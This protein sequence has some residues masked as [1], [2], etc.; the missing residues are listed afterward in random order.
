MCIIPVFV[1]NF[2]TVNTIANL[3][4]LF[5]LRPS[6]LSDPSILKNLTSKIKNM[7]SVITKH[8]FRIGQISKSLKKK[9]SQ[10]QT[11][12]ANRRKFVFQGEPATDPY[13]RICFN[14]F[15]RTITRLL[16]KSV[17]SIKQFEKS[18]IQEY[19]RKG[20]VPKKTLSAF[21][22]HQR[23][24]IQIY[25]DWLLI[26]SIF[27]KRFPDNTNPLNPDWLRELFDLRVTY[28]LGLKITSS[29]FISQKE[30]EYYQQLSPIL[31]KNK[32]KAEDSQLKQD[33]GF[34]QDIRR[35]LELFHEGNISE[36][37]ASKI[38]KIRSQRVFQ[39]FLKEFIC[40]DI[41]SEKFAKTIS[42]SLALI[43]KSLETP[44]PF[45]KSELE[46]MVRELRAGL[47]RNQMQKARHF[48]LWYVVH[49]TKHG[50]LQPQFI[51]S[52]LLD[53][54]D[55]FGKQS[56]ELL[57]EILEREFYFLAEERSSSERFQYIV[58]TLESKKCPNLA[59][60]QAYHKLM[61]IIGNIVQI[62]QIRD[63]GLIDSTHKEQI[64]AKFSTSQNIYASKTEIIENYFFHVF[65]R[66]G[67]GQTLS[68][69]LKAL[70]TVADLGRFYR[71]VA[72][73]FVRYMKVKKKSQTRC[74]V[75]L[76]KML[77][78][79]HPF[80]A[81]FVKEKFFS[82][83]KDLFNSCFDDSKQT[84]T[85]LSADVVVFGE[86]GLVSETEMLK[87]LRFIKHIPSRRVDLWWKLSFDI[88]GQLGTVNF[89]R[90]LGIGEKH[91]QL[92]CRLPLSQLLN[93]LVD[94][95]RI[96]KM[97]FRS[98]TEKLKSIKKN[99]WLFRMEILTR[100][101]RLY[102]PEKGYS[103]CLL[104][105]ILEYQWDVRAL[106]Q[107]DS[108]NSYLEFGSFDIMKNVL[109]RVARGN[110]KQLLSSRRELYRGTSYRDILILVFNFFRE[111][112]ISEHEGRLQK[113]GKG[114]S[115]DVDIIYLTN[116]LFSYVEEVCR[117][118]RSSNSAIEPENK[119][120]EK[121]SQASTQKE[122][123]E[124]N[125]PQEI[126][127]EKEEEVTEEFE[128]EMSLFLEQQMGQAQDSHKKV[129]FKINSLK[130]TKNVNAP[131]GTSGFTLISR[132]NFRKVK[133]I[134]GQFMSK[135][136]HAKLFE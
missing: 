105:F 56:M 5:W 116:D 30:F 52:I 54:A 126:S 109:R 68:E 132:Q 101:L 7:S 131:K 122:E 66:C 21:R 64:L 47:R 119:K 104:A 102:Y 67:A 41:S 65:A 95:P 63:I 27:Q 77:N 50:I 120:E 93:Y 98:S 118:K 6:D 90:S 10:M 99:E 88:K 127:T 86:F 96:R 62:T 40:Q 125:S 11:A 26:Q 73:Q 53:L 83:L 76:L 117:M 72:S 34:V 80:V 128:N 15:S 106:R 14:Q 4:L 130:F 43:Q 42:R 12:L 100:I 32:K 8:K 91:V 51:L 112:M 36:E 136:K 31:I 78:E 16:E 57:T 133:N 19:L 3:I 97:Q 61:A 24:L 81:Y 49:L 23:D 110:F 59:C 35:T 2:R 121:E 84:K 115:E 9:L 18:L 103:T 22:N 79:Y 87:T 135:S 45:I 94:L 82:T 85:N 58:R 89:V 70:L 29:S 124:E 44:S 111:Y 129:F 114:A 113:A 37:L 123:K 25:A 20:Q 134:N 74:L 1:S 71:Q 75:E 107:R 28:Q 69:T 33:E 17:Q 60:N 108:L 13:D 92:L 46:H 55:D 39:S 48:R 38:L